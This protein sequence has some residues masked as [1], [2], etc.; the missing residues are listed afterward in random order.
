MNHDTALDRARKKIAL[1]KKHEEDLISGKLERDAVKAKAQTQL[2]R[3]IVVCNEHKLCNINQTAWAVFDKL[4]ETGLTKAW[5]DVLYQRWDSLV[6]NS[7]SEDFVLQITAL[8][9]ETMSKAQKNKYATNIQVWLANARKILD[10]TNEC[11]REAKKAKASGQDTSE[12]ADAVE[13]QFR[14]MAHLATT[15]PEEYVCAEVSS[16]WSKHL[17]M[18]DYFEKPLTEEEKE[19]LYSA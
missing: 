16:I 19:K 4:T 9:P 10:L 18:V 13:K 5:R 14:F 11:V 3:M 6:S 12:A 7:Q 15:T 1:A 8:L 17:K 2:D